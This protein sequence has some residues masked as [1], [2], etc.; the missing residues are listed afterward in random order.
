MSGEGHDGQAIPRRVVLAHEPPFRVGKLKVIPAT[1]QVESAS[2]AQTVEPRVMKVLVA[3]GRHCGQVVTRDELIEY[4]WDGSVVGDDAINRVLSRIRQI[5]SSIG[6]ASFRV[7]TITK[8]GYRLTATEQSAQANA[9]ADNFPL[10]ASR[11][12]VVLTGGAALAGSALVT[13]GLI[14]RKPTYKPTA[15]ARL[16]YEKGMESLQQ[17]V[18]GTSHQAEAYFRQAVE[19]DPNY[20]DAW[21]AL[22]LAVVSNIGGDVPPARVL[23]IQERARLAAD[24]ALALDSGQ[25]D[26]RLTLAILPGL[27]RRWRRAQ[28]DLTAILKSHPRHWPSVSRLGFFYANV[29]RWDDAIEAFRR[30]RAARPLHATTTNVLATA[31]WSAGLFVQAEAESALAVERWPRLHSTWFTRMMILTYGGKADAAAAFADNPDHH[32]H[33]VDDQIELRRLTAVALADRDPRRIADVKSRLLANV[34]RS[35]GEVPAALRLHASLGDIDT[36]FELLDAYYFGRGRFAPPPS[37]IVP[38][39]HFTEFLFYPAS[40]RLWP[41]PRF[42]QLMGELGLEAYWRSIGFV[43]VALRI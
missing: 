24:R 2:Q 12:T 17:G 30:V 8:V 18:H 16:L 28:A 43:P 21:G 9:S 25:P 1:R 32:P 13:A 5:A 31:Y 7:E 19:A 23:T 29:A 38:V 40:R 39:Q 33:G 41:D 22:A 4:C 37:G 36:C 6:D 3:L 42:K 34:E 14:L 26:A 35:I 27:F 11:R 10:I 20:A 15:A